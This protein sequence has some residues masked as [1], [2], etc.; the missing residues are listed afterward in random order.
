M[1]NG[2]SFSWGRQGRSG[3]RQWKCVPIPMSLVPLT[4]TPENG[5]NGECGC[6]CILPQ[7]KLHKTILIK[8]RNKEESNLVL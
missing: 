7:L 3:D 6:V 4:Y 1:Q 8:T 2:R 5:S